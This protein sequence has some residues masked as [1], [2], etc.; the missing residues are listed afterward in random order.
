MGWT[1]EPGC[2]LQPVTQL[3]WTVEAKR[4]ATKGTTT[5]EKKS[6]RGLEV[7][8]SPIEA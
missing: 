1:G 7:V 3:G 2:P 4:G 6:L 5:V 8:S